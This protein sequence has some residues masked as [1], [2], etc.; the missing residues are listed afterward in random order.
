VRD[1]G[2]LNSGAIPTSVPCVV[3]KSTPFGLLEFDATG[4]SC[5]DEERLTFT[6]TR[7]GTQRRVQRRAACRIELRSEARYRDLANS[8]SEWKRAELCDVSIGGASLR[9][10]REA[11][12]V[13]R[14]LLI[15]FSLNDIIFS[16]PSVV[17]RIEGRS[18]DSLLYA[19]EYL[20]P[21]DRLQDRLAKAIS[22]LQLRIIGSRVKID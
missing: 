7:E 11:L 2:C 9:L 21:G 20:E 6:V 17:R 15:E 1:P 12:D 10:H 19:L 16:L 5:W 8:G 13:G 4:C 18:S 22:Q 3:R 14:E